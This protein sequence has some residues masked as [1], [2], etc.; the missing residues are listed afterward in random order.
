MKL[1]IKTIYGITRKAP[2]AYEFQPELNH[3]GAKE[4]IRAQQPET[5]IAVIQSLLSKE[6][7]NY[8]HSE[9]KLF[10]RV[11]HNTLA[12]RESFMRWS[13]EL[14]KLV[15]LH[16]KRVVVEIGSDVAEQTLSLRWPELKKTGAELA[17]SEF[18]AR[19][20]R[21]DRLR[22]YQWQ[23]CLFDAG[24]TVRMLDA[25]ALI[26]CRRRSVVPIATSVMTQSQSILSML[27]GQDWQQGEY[28]QT[29]AMKSK[30]SSIAGEGV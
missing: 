22:R 11:T 19:H 13:Q 1:K 12:Y 15:A 5:D 25:T 4:V 10:V 28:L 27:S 24:R 8:V 2:V 30:A 16:K 18:G 26:V 9:A 21:L 6:H 23:Y 17:L 14:A 7:D 3:E 20:S 29:V